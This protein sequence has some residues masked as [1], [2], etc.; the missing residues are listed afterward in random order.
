MADFHCGSTTGLT[1]EPTNEIQ[2]KLLDTY[3]DCINK[4]GKKPNIVVLNGDGIDGDDLRGKDVSKNL[5][6]EQVN[7][8]A[9]L[10]LMWDAVDEYIIVSGTPYHTSVN[11]QPVDSFIEQSLSDQLRML[12]NTTTK[13]TYT[14]KDKSIINGWFRLET[15]H[16]I[17]RSVIPHGKSTPQT[18]AKIWNVLNA[19]LKGDKWA[20]LMVFAHVH[21][22][23][24]QGDAFGKVISLPCWQAIG[25]RYGDEECDGHI[26]I[27]A[28]KLVISEEENKWQ[29]TP[30]IYGASMTS[31]WKNR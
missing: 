4:F 27:G 8:A 28:V 29:L 2:E 22:W 26:D 3:Q 1:S 10:L 25:S 12:G 14:R 7:D 11:G 15:R 17:G 13:T 18:R 24:E 21:Y 19:A 30:L 9:K 5:V 16:K 20:H 31:R 23:N 6:N